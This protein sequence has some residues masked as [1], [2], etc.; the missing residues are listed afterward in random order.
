MGESSCG[1]HE[2]A[3]WD[4]G[5]EERVGGQTTAPVLGFAMSSTG[6]RSPQTSSWIGPAALR[7]ANQWSDEPSGTQLPRGGFGDQPGLADS[8]TWFLLLFPNDCLS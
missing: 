6:P 8:E 3:A 7:R 4:C 2:T 1:S 5:W